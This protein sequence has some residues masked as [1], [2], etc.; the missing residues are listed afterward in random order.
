[1]QFSINR[2]EIFEEVQTL[3]IMKPM[4]KVLDQETIALRLQF[5]ESSIDFYA[6]SDSCGTVVD[7]NSAMLTAFGY[8]RHEVVGGTWIQFVHEADLEASAREFE[9][10]LLTGKSL[11]FMSRMRC[12]DGSFK[13]IEWDS[14][15]CPH[16]NKILTLGRDISDSRRSYETLNGTVSLQR[17]IIDSADFAIITTDA[18]GQIQTFNR[19]AERMLGYTAKEVIGLRSPLSFFD[20]EELRDYADEL[21][22]GFGMSVGKGIGVLFA[23]ARAGLVEEGDFTLTRK[24]SHTFPAHV[25]IGA[26]RNEADEIYAFLFVAR[27]TTVEH[28]VE[29]LKNEFISTVSHEL[30]TPMTSIRGSLGLIEGGLAG[31][32]PHEAKMLVDMAINSTDRLIR[33]VNDI[34]DIEKIDSGKMDFKFRDVEVAP[35]VEKAIQSNASFADKHKV[36]YRFSKPLPNLKI[37]VD[38][39]RFAQILDNLLSNAAKYTTEGDE[40]EVQMKHEDDRVRVSVIDHGKGIPDSFKAKVFSKFMQANGSDKRKKGGTGLGLAICK[41]LVENQGGAIN[42]ES[43]EGKGTT[44]Y[45]DFPAV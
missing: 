40:I 16:T 37:K 11:A 42:F 31:P 20:V 38:V 27:D 10:M 34:L 7:I 3:H 43:E 44:F 6:I 14:N 15:I 5:F 2:A 21:T 4:S 8:E 35:L 26:L 12:K 41:S 17:A 13:L 18:H 19:R 9:K 30:R 28:R 32:I 39:D 45:F 36:S 24:S 29:N 33:L 25:S 23:K 22:K 1:V